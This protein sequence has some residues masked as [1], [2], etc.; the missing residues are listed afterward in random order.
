MTEPVSSPTLYDVARAAGV[1]LATASRALNGSA[2]KVNEEYRDRVLAA[3]AELGYTPNLSAQAVARGA[4]SIVALLV[5][6]IADPYFSSIAA[7]VIRAAEAEGLVVTM[8]VTERRADREIELVRMLRGQRPRAIVLAGSRFT[9]ESG[10]AELV[11][12]LDA[13]TAAGG[14]VVLISRHEFPFDTVAIDNAGGAEALARELVGLGYQGFAVLAGPENLVTARDRLAAFT[15]GLGEITPT[16]LH[17]AFTRDAGYAAMT[18]LI[19]RGLDGIDLVFAVNDVMAI[20]AMSALRDH[21]IDVPGR[22]GVAGFDDVSIARDVSPALTTV[23][24]P[25]EEAGAASIALA[26]GSTGQASIPAEVVL[27]ES[28]PRR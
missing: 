27:R 1:S 16:V 22:I 5:S 2:R 24:V 19:D 7:G 9:E 3:A 14:R 8:A 20:G 10:S 17:G 12:E 11:A 6:D 4:S 23:R 28:T 18:E 15:A 25:L 13:F 21:G 26:I